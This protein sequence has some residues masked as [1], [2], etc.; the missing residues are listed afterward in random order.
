MSKRK[1][2]IKQKSIRF[3]KE[4]R[5]FLD[6]WANDHALNNENQSVNDI[7]NYAEGHYN[8]HKA[9]VEKIVMDCKMNRIT[10]KELQHEW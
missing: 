10:I 1:E 6:R 2:K 3:T 7:F 4:S 5:A 8:K 9:R